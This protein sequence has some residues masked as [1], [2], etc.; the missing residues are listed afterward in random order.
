MKEKIK[1]YT[2]EFLSF[3]ARKI[4]IY[5]LI[6]GI[7][8]AL[9]FFVFPKFTFQAYSERLIWTGIGVA[10][11]ATYFLFWSGGLPR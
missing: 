9:S 7:L 11:I 5:D 2:L 1:A 3:L 10:L 6:L 4:L 8:A